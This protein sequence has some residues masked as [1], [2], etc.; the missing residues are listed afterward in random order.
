M[1]LRTS[2]LHRGSTNSADRCVSAPGLEEQPAPPASRRGRG[3]A[4]GS[5]QMCIIINNNNNDSPTSALQNACCG[6]TG[7]Q[8]HASASSSLRHRT[9]STSVHK[10]P[11]TEKGI[12]TTRD[13][14]P[15]WSPCWIVAQMWRARAPAGDRSVPLG[16]PTSLQ[17]QAASTR[18]RERSRRGG[19]TLSVRVQLSVF[20]ECFRYGDQGGFIR[21]TAR[22]LPLRVVFPAGPPGG[23]VV[24]PGTP[25]EVPLARC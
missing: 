6:C 14:T 9:S 11:W 16:S 21:L 4:A 15:L 17:L 20:L 25:P 22:L 3:G 7:A 18:A 2:A 19:R 1:S 24:P 10:M 12:F 5:R 13:V 23:A 8:L